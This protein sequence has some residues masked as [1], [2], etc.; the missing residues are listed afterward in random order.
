MKHFMFLEADRVLNTAIQGEYN[1]LL[2]ILS[3]LVAITATYTSFL[4][5][6]R[7]QTCEKKNVCIAWLL[8]GA[9][10]LGTG[11]WSM[12]FI[13]MLAFKLPVTVSYDVLTTIISIIPA[14]LASLIVLNT[15][16]AKNANKSL[17]RLNQQLGFRRN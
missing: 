2:V 15:D 8:A 12:H 9:V 3:I 7:I 14:L 1:F 4:L 17:L 6:E 16:T 5:S 11:I 13:G 10:S